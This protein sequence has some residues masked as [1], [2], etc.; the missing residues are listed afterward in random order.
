MGLGVSVI[1]VGPIIGLLIILTSCFLDEQLRLWAAL[2]NNTKE[3]AA[4]IK[5]NN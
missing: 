5:N 2:V 3:I 1:I 4:N